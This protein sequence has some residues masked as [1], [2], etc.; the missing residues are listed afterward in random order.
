MD[1]EV[2]KIRE[3]RELL[4]S[5]PYRLGF[6]PRESV[7]AIS[8]RA[9]RNRLGLVV[10]VDIA[11]LAHR[12]GGGPLAD[13][14]AAH[15]AADGA[16]AVVLVVY[17]TTSRPDVETGLGAAGSA[18]EQMR[19]ALPPALPVDCWIVGPGGYAGLDCSDDECC[20]P[21]GRPLT[22]L[23]STQ[24]GAHMVVAGATIA[25]TREDLAL[26]ARAPQRARRL[27]AEEAARERARRRRAAQA[28]ERRGDVRPLEVWRA[29]VLEVWCDLVRLA[30]A[31]EPLPAAA[32]G[33]LL[34]GLSD[35][36]VRDRLL[37]RLARPDGWSRRADWGLE[38]ATA[39]DPSEEV[40]DRAVTDP[41]R[42][43]LETVAAHAS[44][45]RL[46]PVL[47]VLAWLAWWHGDG[48]R[49]S[50]LTEQ[51]LA[52]E[53]G[54]GL[55]RILAELLGTG[56]PPAWIRADNA[57]VAAGAESAGSAG[58]GAESAG[59]ASAGSASAPPVSVEPPETGGGASG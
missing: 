47:A 38:G 27:A 59:S 50:V 37:I 1:T 58:A 54:H 13:A 46:A 15:L 49:A 40:P 6:R 8:V 14:V 56:T 9:D 2:I 43:V 35:V 42:T 7:V 11:D 33:R 10:R 25:E 4:A 34:V 23:E 19:A 21:G 16:A 5:V 41:A 32:V 12:D 39:F 48:A 36:I 30:R 20:P 18:L 52:A 53:P 28:R 51:C 22:D 29:T 17:T 57:R 24:I 44:R 26:R 3:P 55:G 45:V 31:R